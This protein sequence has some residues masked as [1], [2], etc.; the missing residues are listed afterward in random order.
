M[1]GIAIQRKLKGWT[2]QELADKMGVTANTVYRWESSNPVYKVDPGTE[3]LKKMSDLFSCTIDDLVSG[4]DSNP[5]QS[6]GAKEKD[7]N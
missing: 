4:D 2:Q 3:N 5:I 7:T 1:K 6:A